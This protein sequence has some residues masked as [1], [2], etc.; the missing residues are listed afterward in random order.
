[1]PE[2][3]TWRIVADYSQ[4]EYLAIVGLPALDH[5]RC[6]ECTFAGPAGSEG[7]SADMTR[8]PILQT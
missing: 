5:P 1:M 8:D 6:A 2:G 3:S 7:Y 4:T